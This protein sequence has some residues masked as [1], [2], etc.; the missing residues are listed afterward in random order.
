MLSDL[1]GTKSSRPTSPAGGAAGLLAR[2]RRPAAL[3][4]PALVTPAGPG[5]GAGGD[6]VG[7]YHWDCSDWCGGALPAISE[8]TANERRDSSSPGSARSAAAQ[9]LPP[10]PLY[11]TSSGIDDDDARYDFTDG[12]ND[13]MPDT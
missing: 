3:A 5:A 10:P 7:G 4:P 2:A 8:L 9:L 1:K 6:L 11:D 12:T 13:Q